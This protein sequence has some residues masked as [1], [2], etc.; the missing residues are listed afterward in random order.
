MFEDSLYFILGSIIG[1]FLNV[2][3]YRLPRNLSIISPRSFCPKCDEMIPFYRNIPILSFIFQLGKCN[4]CSGKISIHY[5][6]IEIIS[7]VALLV[8]VILFSYPE[9][10]LFYWMFVHLFV[11][12]VIDQKWMKI[13]ISLLISMTL[14]LMGYHLIWTVDLMVP[15]SGLIVGIGFIVFVVGLNWLIFHKQTMGW[16]DLILVVILGAW[17]GTIQIFLTIFLASIL[18]LVAFLLFSIING[19]NRAKYLPFIP[20]LS[21]SAIL[22]YLFYPL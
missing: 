10:V 9:A 5:P 16:G 6:I 4:H 17:L 18:A 15:I 21:I 20:Y 3:I 1:S 11:L 8:T 19:F 7:A 13:P 12:S 2:I 22:I 14:G